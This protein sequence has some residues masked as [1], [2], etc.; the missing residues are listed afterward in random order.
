MYDVK[1]GKAKDFP[2][3]S[4]DTLVNR[5]RIH[6]PFPMARVLLPRVINQN[7]MIV[8]EFLD[9]LRSHRMPFDRTGYMPFV[10]DAIQAPNLGNLTV[11]ASYGAVASQRERFLKI[12]PGVYSALLKGG[13]PVFQ[14]PDL[15]SGVTGLEHAIMALEQDQSLLVP[16][17]EIV[18]HL[19]SQGQIP[20]SVIRRDQWAIHML[21]IEGYLHEAV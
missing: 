12:K 20:T 19:Q 9:L 10:L 17:G 18:K 4:R 13:H 16:V 8:K 14:H 5:L 1:F 11:L 2:G 7:A 3:L 15:P 6:G 21:K